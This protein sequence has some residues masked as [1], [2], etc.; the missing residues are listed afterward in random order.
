MKKITALLIGLIISATVFAGCGKSN[1]SS[2]SGGSTLSNIKSAG[3]IVIG[4]D[5]TYP[6]MEFRD[7]NGKLVG[8]D[9]DVA[10][11]VA[12]KLGV[13]TKY[14]PTAWDGIFLALNSKK[15]DI[16]Q[17]SVS[18]TDDRKKNMIFSD[19][20]IYGGSSIFVKADNTTIKTGDDLKGKIVGCQVGTTSQDVL[21]KMSGLKEVKKYNAMTDAFMDLANGRVEAVVSDPEVG[22]YY[23]SSQKD[24]IKRLSSALNEEPIGVAFR[25]ND[26]EL[27]DAYQKALNELKQDGTLS[28]ISEKWFGNDI[29]KDKK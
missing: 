5:D 15:F 13:K 25:K 23:I 1:T 21:S 4:V 24:K 26:T 10:D 6:P 22:D 8:F 28:K 9:V 3:T 11:A 12:K 16:I 2:N 27:R 19:P 29:Y 14:V 20:Y 18:I 7:K 17:S